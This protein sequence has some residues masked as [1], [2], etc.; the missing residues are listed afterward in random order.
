MPSKTVNSDYAAS[1]Q[2]HR[3][4]VCGEEDSLDRVILVGGTAVKEEKTASFF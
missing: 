1:I 2:W 3:S 4:K